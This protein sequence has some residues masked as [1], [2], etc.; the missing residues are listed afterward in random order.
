MGRRSACTEDEA[1]RNCEEIANSGGKVT[2][3]TLR[4]ACGGQGSLGTYQAYVDKW[5]KSRDL[6]DEE[7]REIDMPDAVAAH[8]RIFWGHLKKESD[9]RFQ[10][11]MQQSRAAID[12]ARQEVDQIRNLADLLEEE[13]EKLQVAVDSLRSEC[14]ELKTLNHVLTDTVKEAK[15][16][17]NSSMQAER[18]RAEENA[19]LRGHIDQ[20]MDNTQVCEN[21]VRERDALLMT[22]HADMAA[23]R[24]RHELLTSQQSPPK[25]AP[26]IK[27]AARKSSKQTA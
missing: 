24:E 18:E 6:L 4:Q 26:L 22:A 17:Q 25:R 3:I 21:Q 7:Q 23:L 20:I 13:K 15:E 5:R 10:F 1:I 27:T 12:A 14:V 2:A 9:K 8:C 11:V 16:S 19:K